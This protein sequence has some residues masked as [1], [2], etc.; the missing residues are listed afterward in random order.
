MKSYEEVVY[1]TGSD[2]PSGGSQVGLL[3]TYRYFYDRRRMC[4]SK[5]LY[6]CPEGKG[7]GKVSAVHCVKRDWTTMPRDEDVGKYY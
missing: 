1:A 2:P 4:N 5:W 3:V 7:M 6:H